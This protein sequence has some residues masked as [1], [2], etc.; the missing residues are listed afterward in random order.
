M[1][2]LIRAACFLF[3]LSIPNLAWADPAVA[4]KGDNLE[5]A[6]FAGGCFWCMES[7]YTELPGVK[8]VV[9]GYT[10]GTKLNP[11]YQEVCAGT[12]G[13]AE[14]VEVTFDPKEISYEKLLDVFWHNIDPTTVDEQFADHGSQ[15]RTAIFYHSPQQQRLAEAS[16]QKWEQA[17]VFGNAIVTEI[18]PA[19]VFYP[20][21]EYHQGYCRINPLRY[22]LYRAASGR[23]AYLKKIW[24]KDS[25]H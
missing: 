25:Q 24:G 12:T 20:A 14:A 5:K 9:S 1:G 6:T 7:P 18:T 17:G 4:D 3:V 19:A 8:K 2:H 15:Y 23:D 22:N 11:T 16:K 21:E 10:G 13:H